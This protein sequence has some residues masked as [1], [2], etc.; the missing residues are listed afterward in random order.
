MVATHFKRIKHSVLCVTGV[1]LRDISY[2]IFVIL[3]LNVSRLIDC[4]S[5][6][7]YFYHISSSSYVVVVVVRSYERLFM[8]HAESSHAEHK[9][10]S[11][12]VCYTCWQ[13]V[14]RARWRLHGFTRFSS[15]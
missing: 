8:A 13:R 5:C 15:V 11:M 12:S 4:S 2:M 1:Y 3:Y 14:I 7:H 6:Y 10:K 9:A